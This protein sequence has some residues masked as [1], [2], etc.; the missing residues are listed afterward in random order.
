MDK[1]LQMLEESDDKM[2]DIDNP[3]NVNET[4][5]E[6]VV[7]FPPDDGKESEENSDVDDNC[8]LNHLSSRQQ[9]SQAEIVVREDDSP[10]PVNPTQKKT[11]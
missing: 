2:S 8:D 1:I 5:I 3:T 9:R 11:E 6:Y 4:D 10:E 7:I